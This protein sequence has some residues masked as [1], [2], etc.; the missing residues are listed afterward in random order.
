MANPQVTDKTRRAQGPTVFIVLP[1]TPSQPQRREDSKLCAEGQA[2]N[3]GAEAPG[4][5]GI[6]GGTK[7]PSQKASV[8]VIVWR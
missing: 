3:V 4:V 7:E 5:M 2:N 8:W 1:P 6:L